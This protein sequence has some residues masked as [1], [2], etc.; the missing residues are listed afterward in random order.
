MHTTDLMNYVREMNTKQGRI[1]TLT[2]VLADM[3]CDHNDINVLDSNGNLRDFD[4]LSSLGEPDIVC[5]LMVHGY[6]LE[7]L[8]AFCNII[9]Q[10]NDIDLLAA[11]LEAEYGNPLRLFHT[12]AELTAFINDLRNHYK[13][14]P[15]VRNHISLGEYVYDNVWGSENHLVGRPYINF[16]SVGRDFEHTGNAI[17]TH[18]GY[19]VKH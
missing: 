16:E 18:Y 8:N 1:A 7:S 17:R 9:S 4:E 15:N 19:I 11:T 13:L 5:L 6:T 14:L 10:F 12:P 2:K 3:N